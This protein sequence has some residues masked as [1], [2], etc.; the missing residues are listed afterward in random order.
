MHHQAIRFGSV[1]FSDIEIKDILKAWI[2]L[3]FAFAVLLAGL[4]SGLMA[5][6]V[7]SS[8]TV[9]IGFIA[10]ELGHKVMAQ[11]Y[12]AWAEFRAWNQGLIIAVIMSFFGFILAAPGAV[13]IEGRTIG[14]RRYGIIAAAGPVMSYAAALFFLAAALLFPTGVFNIIGKYG[15]TINSWLGLFNMMPIFMLDGKKIWDWDKGWFILLLGFGIALI[16]LNGL[17]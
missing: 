15:F 1:S 13:M 16:V 12:G 10:H 7:I 5:A 8:L 6:F 9:G 3:S 17:L 11:H 2:A 4:T 14:R